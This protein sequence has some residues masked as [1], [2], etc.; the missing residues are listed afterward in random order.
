VSDAEAG[1]TIS[2]DDA[3]HGAAR[4]GMLEL[5]SFRLELQAA[6]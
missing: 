6:G 4:T 2:G 5:V 1:C 3:V